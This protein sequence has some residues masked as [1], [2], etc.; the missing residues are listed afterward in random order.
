[1]SAASSASHKARY[2]LDVVDAQHGQIAADGQPFGMLTPTSS[3]LD[4]PRPGASRPRNRGR[5]NR[6]GA[7]WHGLDDGMDDLSDVPARGDLRK[8]AVTGGDRFA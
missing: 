7:C 3:E 4:Q 1:M 2:A 6:D 5:R 8:D